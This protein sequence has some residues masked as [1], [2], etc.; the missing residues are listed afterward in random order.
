[1]ST[2]T[3]EPKVDPIVS[4]VMPA[5]SVGT[6]VLWYKH[7]RK[8]NRAVPAVVVA[9]SARNIQCRPFT[10]SIIYEAV[11]HIDDPKL[12]LSADQRETGAWDYTEDHHRLANLE[13]RLDRI[14]ASLG[15]K[16]PKAPEE[17]KDPRDFQAE[18]RELKEMA[19]N[20]GIEFTGNPKR[21]WLEE[22]IANRSPST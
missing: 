3:E 16:V 1:M 12:E 7:A 2:A 17:P 9:K 10:A 14:E 18:Y 6:T 22:A 20:L 4:F 5:V 21:A 19:T 13:R 8:T 15:D 11:R